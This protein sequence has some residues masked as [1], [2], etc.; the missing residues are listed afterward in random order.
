MSD[1]VIKS[2]LEKYLGRAIASEEGRRLVI[3]LVFQDIQVLSLAAE[4]EIRKQL[5]QLG[6]N[7]TKLAQLIED[8]LD[9][10]EDCN[11]EY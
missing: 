8:L 7:A 2:S 4:P 9:H 6:E 11:T 5:A 3:E 1:D 10:T